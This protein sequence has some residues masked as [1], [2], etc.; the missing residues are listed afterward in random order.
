[1]AKEVKNM[2]F[3]SL[4]F[5]LFSSIADA[6]EALDNNKPK[7]ARDILIRAQQE[8]EENYISRPDTDDS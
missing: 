4:Y 8:A 1:M 7:S 3:K 5:Y 2:D 6:V